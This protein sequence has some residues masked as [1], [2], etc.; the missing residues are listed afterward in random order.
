MSLAELEEKF[1]TLA[2]PVLGNEKVSKIIEAVRALDNMNDLM[3]LG[4]LLRPS[5]QNCVS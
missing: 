1:A 3:E 4:N 5:G 2:S